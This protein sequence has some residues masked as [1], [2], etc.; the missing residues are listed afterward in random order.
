VLH[1]YPWLEARRGGVPRAI[2]E[3]ARA[4]GTAGHAVSM[5]TLAGSDMDTPPGVE[6]VDL[7]RPAVGG[8]RFR[9]R[10][11]AVLRR[12]LETSDVLHLHGLWASGNAHVAGMAARLGVPYVVSLHG[13]L[14]DWSMEQRPLKKA[15]Y[16]ATIGRKLLAGA[17]VVH[18]G[19][20]EEMRQSS[21]RLPPGTPAVT[22]PY[23]ADLAERHPRADA[24]SGRRLLG[25][26]E[27]TAIILFLGRLHPVKGV[28]LLLE[29]M[30]GLQGDPPHLVIAGSGDADY[31][32]RLRAMAADLS[33]DCTFVGEVA[34]DTK[35][36]LLAVADALVL[37]SR[38]ES[39]GMVVLEALSCATP[40]IIT[41]GV[42]LWRELEP[43]GAA[44]IAERSAAAVAEAVGA[45][46]AD[47]AEAERMGGS[48]RRW[49]TES[50][51]TTP[52]RVASIYRSA[53]GTGPPSAGTSPR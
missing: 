34:D 43:S 27:G 3:L 22:V 32:E 10:E 6:R 20:I 17:G 45:V 12:Q 49:L 30:A 48:G 47:R 23:P 29:A 41:K 31:V 28:E 35:W 18:A 39:Y 51:D 52:A 26:T 42:A 15:A 13:Q 37:P 7:A 25:V 11:A 14:D 19:T 40:V 1:Y 4:M 5:V 50:L 9:R 2:V 36:S 46:L 16:R 24:D 21:R 33:I 53:L 38:H 8:I 44:I